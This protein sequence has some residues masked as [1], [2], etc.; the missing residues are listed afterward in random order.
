LLVLAI[1]ILVAR[2]L[3]R[4]WWLAGGPVLVAFAVVAAL[5][6]PVFG[7]GLQPL[8]DRALAAD[9]RSFAAREGLGD[10]DVGVVKVHRQT[11][12]AN[13]EAVGIGPTA[14]VELWDT[15]LDGRFTRPEVRVVVAHELGHIARRHIWKGLAWFALFSLPLAYVLAAAA[16]RRGGLARPAAVPAVLAAAAALQILS[17]PVAGTLSRRYEAEADWVALQTTRDP[18][19]ARGLF[20]RFA[21]V[22][23]DQPRPPSW[24]YVLLSDHPALIQRIAMAE[25]WKRRYSP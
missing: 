3:G 14:R 10:A 25:A 13:A 6:E 19:G 16:E 7:A 11:R 17:L 12:I 9:V 22:N 24:A 8:R 21:V 1:L 23:L 5:V 18:A 2:R 20:E 4:R 15:L